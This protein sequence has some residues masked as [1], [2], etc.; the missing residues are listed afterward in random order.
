MQ[1]C[2]HSATR[3]QQLVLTAAVPMNVA[4]GI[5]GYNSKRTAHAV[6]GAK[7]EHAGID[8]RS[9]PP[10]W[11]VLEQNMQSVLVHHEIHT[12][13]EIGISQGPVIQTLIVEDALARF[14]FA[15][16]KVR[17]NE[18]LQ[19]LQN[20]EESNPDITIINDIL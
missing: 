11:E 14:K 7:G 1:N 12:Q 18:A 17:K 4:L 16:F 20:S 3:K 5:A 10:T 9:N 19:L 2:L 15:T 13:K 8:L 6:L